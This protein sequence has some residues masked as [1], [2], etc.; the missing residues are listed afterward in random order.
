M[1]YYYI[2]GTSKGLGKELALQILSNK[3]NYVFGISRTQTIEHKNYE[4]I[5]LDLDNLDAVNS[6]NFPN[7]NDAKSITLI[8]NAGIIGEIKAVGNRTN[9]DI[10][11]T[12]NINSI[13]PSILMNEFV[14]AYQNT[15]LN[16]TIL[17][18]SSGAG[19]HTIES[20]AV[21]CASKSALDMYSQV[22]YDEQKHQQKNKAIKI[23]SVAPG[24][25]DTPMQDEIRKAKAKDFPIVGNFINYK[26]SGALNSPKEIAEIL[27]SFLDNSKK[28]KK[29]IYDVREL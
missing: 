1:N 16:K 2:T 9:N 21:Y 26:K 23:Y 13:A 22:F 10:I 7:H 20:W 29:V 8:N 14:K 11:S 5:L 15:D 25:V 17:N 12:Y 18:I 27:I 4:H 6:F 28:Y 24:I 19:R 3:N